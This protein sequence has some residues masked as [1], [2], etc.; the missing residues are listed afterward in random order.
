MLHCTGKFYLYDGGK[1]WGEA[2]RNPESLDLST[3]DRERMPVWMIITCP[4]VSSSYN[5]YKSPVERFLHRNESLREKP[6]RQPL[7]MLGSQA[8]RQRES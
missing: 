2:G 5:S 8:Q 3:I 7:K 4:S 6:N 1:S